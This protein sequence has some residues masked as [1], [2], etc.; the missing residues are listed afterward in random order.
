MTAWN[1]HVPSVCPSTVLNGSS[2]PTYDW[3]SS[4][5]A[6]GR[7]A[8]LGGRSE[9]HGRWQGGGASRHEQAAKPPPLP[10]LGERPHASGPATLPSNSR[11]VGRH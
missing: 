8:A 7:Q 5:C 9:R 1:G 6:C 4:V 2:K 11:G 10:K 3:K